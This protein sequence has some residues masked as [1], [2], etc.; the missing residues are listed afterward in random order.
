MSDSKRYDLVQEFEAWGTHVHGHSGRVGVHRDKLRQLFRLLV[1]AVAV[2]STQ[3]SVQA[4]LGTVVHPFLHQR[5]CMSCLS[6][7]F[8]WVSDLKRDHLYNFPAVVIDEILACAFILPLCHSNIRAPVSQVVSATDSSGAQAGSCVAQVPG[9]VSDVLFRRSEFRGEHGRLDSELLDHETF[10]SMIEPDQDLNELL[11]C[12]DWKFPRSYAHHGLHH[13]NIQEVRAALDELTRRV[14]QDGERDMRV[15]CAID[16]RVAVGA[17]AKGRS[18]PRS[19]NAWLRRIAIVSLS[20]GVTLRPLW[21]GT[22]WNPADDPSRKVSLRA[23]TPRPCWAE[24]LWPPKQSS[25]SAG[26]P[27]VPSGTCS[28]PRFGAREY[29]GGTGGLRRALC[30]KEVPCL[31]FEA[32]PSGGYD[33]RFDLEL[34]ATIDCEIAAAANR[35]YQYSHFGI[36]CSSWST[37][38]KINGGTRTYAQ[39]LGNGTLPREIKGNLQLAQMM[40]LVFFYLACGIS[41]SIENPRSSYIWKTEAMRSLIERADVYVVDLDMC[42]YCLRPPDYRPGAADIR[43]RKP[44]RIV[45]NLSCL[46]HLARRC[47]GNHQHQVCLGTVRNREGKVV[48]RSTAAG[49]YPPSLCR[50]W[51]ALVSDYFHEPEKEAESAED[52]GVQHL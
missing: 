47:D 2:P 28:A 4:L 12:L 27:C 19:L 29:F 35:E 11:G 23:S 34:D 15:I 1:A 31:G 13:I 17:I 6:E 45:T 3:N 25:T 40:K 30:Q 26:P 42:A 41:F 16:S 9:K 51:A 36:T 7:S 50:R 22:G 14:E 21:V 20:S 33:S 38:N 32:Y 39:P 49:A 18:S 5:T 44:T 8:T 37:I 43:V 24:H 52:Q 10:S 46:R 48:R